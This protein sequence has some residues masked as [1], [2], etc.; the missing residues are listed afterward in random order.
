MH[1]ILHVTPH[2]L[3]AR[4]FGGPVFSVASVCAGI[5][6]D[7]RFR[8]SVI[9]TDAAS[10]NNSTRL[11]LEAN[12][13]RFE[14]GYDVYYAR[15]SSFAEHIRRDARIAA[16]IYIPSGYSSPVLD[17]LVSDHSNLGVG[18]THVEAG[19]LDTARVASSHRGM[20]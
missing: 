9:T 5:A 3:P 2:F 16:Q 8:V 17:L 4:E 14:P 11:G 19:G 10:P 15:P 20:A 6:S 18:P 12:P 1:N 7:D 13:Q